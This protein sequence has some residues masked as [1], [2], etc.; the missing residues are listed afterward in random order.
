MVITNNDITQKTYKKLS[1]QVS[2]SGLSFCVFDAITN[3][4]IHNAI[5]SFENNKVIEE[6]LWRT[7]VDNPVLT[8]SYDKVIVLHN[9]SLNTFVPSS[10]FDVNYLASYLQYNTKVFDTDFFTY[11]TISP[12]E[13]IN[14]YVP[15]VNINNFLLDQYESFE[16]KNSNSILVRKLLDLSK[17]R[18]EKQIFVHIQENRFELVIVK[19]Q[20]LL[21]FNS[22]NY[23]APEDLIYYILFACEQLQLNP[24]TISIKI[25]GDCSEDHPNFKIIYTYIRNCSLLDVSAMSNAF[26]E[27]ESN[28]RNHFTLYHS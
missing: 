14:I 24:E 17:N 26:N 25:L 10:L 22:F 2:L 12:Y 3:K 21:L 18:D 5:V 28:I 27:T 1:I 19:N 13:I 9:N 15:F 7:F 4:I 8:Q 6:Q 16:Y 11:D 23:T 20:E